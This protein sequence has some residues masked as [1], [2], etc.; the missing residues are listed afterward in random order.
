VMA[1]PSLS[2]FLQGLGE[3]IR[4][5]GIG[6]SIVGGELPPRGTKDWVPPS[7]TFSAKVADLAREQIAKNNGDAPAAVESFL[8][9][10][11][12]HGVLIEIPRLSHDFI[13]RVGEV[14][15]KD[16][17]ER[18][19][20]ADQREMVVNIVN[21]MVQE[22]VVSRDLSNLGEP[23][24]LEKVATRFGKY[25]ALDLTRERAARADSGVEAP[26]AP[27]RRVIP[28]AV[29]AQEETQEQG[30]THDP[31]QGRGR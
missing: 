21:E 16:H 4:D 12:S 5:R 27:V 14:F 10:A 19:F 31:D 23:E 1:T 7:G 11:R 30:Q 28:E 15:T 2:K 17:P 22:G 29:Q 9:L 24:M 18:P 6:L 26:R 8:D 20:E 3:A 25:D 13:E